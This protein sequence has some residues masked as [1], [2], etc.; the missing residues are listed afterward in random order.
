MSP[1][2]CS[3]RYHKARHPP[4]GSTWWCQAHQRLDL[5]RSPRR[6]EDLSGERHSRCRHLHGTRETQDGD[7]H[8]CRLRSEAPRTH[9]LRFRLVDDWL[10]GGKR[11]TEKINVSMYTLY[12]D[13]RSSLCVRACSFLPNCILF[14]LDILCVGVVDVLT[15]STEEFTTTLYQKYIYR[16]RV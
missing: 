12:C 4:S 2:M 11:L 7:R 13:T 9:A 16:R 5:R 3:S 15:F 1:L 8:G 14:S 10:D 6:T